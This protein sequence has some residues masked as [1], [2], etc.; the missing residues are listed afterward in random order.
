MKTSLQLPV[1][2]SYRRIHK[3]NMD[4]TFKQRNI[5]KVNRNIRKS[6]VYNQ[7]EISRN[8]FCI[9]CEMWI[10]RIRHLQH[11]L[12][13]VHDRI[14]ICCLCDLPKEVKQRLSMLTSCL[15]SLEKRNKMSKMSTNT[16]INKN[17][18]FK[19]DIFLT[20]IN[21]TAHEGK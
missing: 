8:V 5:P 11:I 6:C 9:S 21:D 15:T 1:V 13:D 17:R 7:K 2:C 18:E 19:I 16:Q 14:M 3:Y 12:I 10:Q 4:K 20:S